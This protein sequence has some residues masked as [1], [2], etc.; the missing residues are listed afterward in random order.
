MGVTFEKVRETDRVDFELITKWDN[1]EAIKYL[2]RPNFYEG[3]IEEASAL[4]LFENFQKSD[5]K[6]LYMILLDGEKVGYVSL[7]SKF[8]MLYQKQHQTGWIS[9]CIGEA[10][11]RHL[12]VGQAAMLF[13]EQ[14]GKALRLE[15]LELGVF[16]Y[17]EKAIAFY[18]KMGYQEIG[19][20]D[21]FVYYQGAWHKDI[22]MEKW[23]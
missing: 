2:I 9:I 8:P 14:L 6:Y 17:N 13:I 21:D 19:R 22:R 7:D 18:D 5:G 4:E 3:E 10:D 1:D 20:I 11:Y 12:G 16:E 23:L 15:R